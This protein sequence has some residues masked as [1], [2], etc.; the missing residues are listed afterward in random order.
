MH[1]QCYI[2]IY[3]RYLSI[4]RI[5]IKIIF[6][7]IYPLGQLNYHLKCPASSQKHLRKNIEAIFIALYKLSL[8]D[9]KSFDKLMLFRNG[10]T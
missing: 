4:N 7:N 2:K 1:Y 5:C 8:N 6:Y 9:Q 3:T 10:I